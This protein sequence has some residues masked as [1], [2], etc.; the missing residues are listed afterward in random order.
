[1]K[2]QIP[3]FLLFLL[4]AASYGDDA[5][6][7]KPEQN[8]SYLSIA[9][10]KASLMQGDSSLDKEMHNHL[11]SVNEALAEERAFLQECYEKA[12]QLYN[13]EAEEESYVAVLAN[14]SR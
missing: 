10:K 9:D 2:R 12:Q 11:L 5:K 1:M 6:E 8:K 3:F 7:S 14:K 13:S 4:G